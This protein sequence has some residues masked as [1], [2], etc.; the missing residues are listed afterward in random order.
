VNGE[1]GDGDDLEVALDALNRAVRHLAAIE[2]SWA[3]RSAHAGDV[4]LDEATRAVHLAIV[5]LTDLAAVS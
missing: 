3:V 4:R 1:V 2:Q 5:E